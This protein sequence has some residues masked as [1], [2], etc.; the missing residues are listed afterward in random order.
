MTVY[1][2]LVSEYLS[3]VGKIMWATDGI[4]FDGRPFSVVG[5]R[6]LDCRFGPMHQRKTARKVPA[7]TFCSTSLFSFQTKLQY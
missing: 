5:H 3:R 7:I 6:Q 4:P 2:L 1:L